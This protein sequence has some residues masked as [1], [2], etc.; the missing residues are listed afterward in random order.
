M[1]LPQKNLPKMDCQGPVQSGKTGA[2]S[3]D[4]VDVVPKPALQAAAAR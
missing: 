4:D 2:N 1:I 3:P